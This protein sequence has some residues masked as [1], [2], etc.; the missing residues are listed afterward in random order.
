MVIANP[1]YDVVFKRLMEN[2]KVAKFFIGTLLEQNIENIEIKPQEFTYVDELVGLALFRVDFIAT[3]KTDTGELKKILIEI[4]KA[5]NQIDLMRFRNYLAEQYKKEDIVNDKKVVLPITTIYILGFKLPE[6]HTACLKVERNYKDLTNNSTLTT[7]SDFVEKLTHDSFIVQVHRI[8]D[9]YK[10]K[11]DKLLSI[12]E[13][14]N[15]V[16]DNKIIK[17]FNHP[18]DL[19]AIKEATNIL[20]YS[21]TDPAEK[22]KI[23]IEQEAWRS[24]NAMFE[25]ERNELLKS[26]TDKDQALIQMQKE[27][28]ALRQKLGEK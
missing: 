18:T 25:N 23:E 7:K 8:T 16:D 27:L 15:F 2:D 11:L 13:Q 12:F 28:D 10:T 14:T 20:H 19:E 6:I 21:G 4:Q 3:I 26:L 1:I 17:Q 24:V 9:V 22:K 5:R